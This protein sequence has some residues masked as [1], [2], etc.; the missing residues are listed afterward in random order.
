M[1]V[2]EGG[3]GPM[4]SHAPRQQE[5]VNMLLGERAERGETEQDQL[6]LNG[7]GVNR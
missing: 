1:V 2:L 4:G 3:E 5:M 7:A 6:G